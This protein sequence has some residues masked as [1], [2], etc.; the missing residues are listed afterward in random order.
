MTLLPRARILIADDEE[1]IRYVLRETLEAEGHEVVE[2]SSG[3]DAVAALAAN[4]FALAFLDIRMPGPSGLELLDRIRALGSGTAVVIMTA[5]NTFEHAIEAMKR[6]ALDYLVKP[7]AMAEILALVEKAGRT[8]ALQQE[9]HR[10]RREVGE[11]TIP[12]DRLVGK[13]SA[14]LEVFKIN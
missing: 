6:G 3:D 5:Q 13:S 12:G 8:R 10:L 7:F 11:R 4:D 1:S 14:L 9:V 2:A